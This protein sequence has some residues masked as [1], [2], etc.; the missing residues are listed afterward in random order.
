VRAANAV[1][2]AGMRSFAFAWT[3][4]HGSRFPI[5]TGAG[6]G[7]MEAANR[8]ASEAGGP[9]IGYTTYYDRHA[10]NDP[11]RPYGGDPRQSLNAFVTQGLIFSSVAL[12]EQAM[13]KHSAAIVL[14]PGGT[15]TEWEI[16][17]V[18]EMIK[19]RQLARVPVYV[20][21]NR[22]RHWRSLDARLQ[23]MAE[24]M[25]ITREEVAFLKYVETEEELLRQLAADL[26]LR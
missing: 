23:D 2:Y 21:G 14:A 26:G 11:A 25:T 8:G 19:S 13:I 3:Q 10:G 16:F 22:Q 12:R 4:R 9:S 15:G 5:M 6:P 24:R 17:Q 1:L 18:V 7:L 20:F